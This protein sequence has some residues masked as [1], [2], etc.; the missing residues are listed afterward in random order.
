M[1]LDVIKEKK[2]QSFRSGATKAG[3]ENL[4]LYWIVRKS[5]ALFSENP[6]DRKRV[7]ALRV[8]AN[9]G[10]SA[11]DWTPGKPQYHHD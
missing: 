7:M 1:S 11:A 5:G 4:P 9:A 8:S 6:T 3:Q 2:I 10:L